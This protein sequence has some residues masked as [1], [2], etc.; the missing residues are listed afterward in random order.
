MGTPAAIEN[1][2]R[3]AA[4]LR[5]ENHPLAEWL[6]EA[7]ALARSGASLEAA[8]NLN[9]GYGAAARA[10]TQHAAL[11]VLADAAPAQSDNGRAA[12]IVEQVDRYRAGAWRRDEKTRKR[13][14]GVA[15]ACFDL[16]ATR[17]PTSLRSLRRR[18]PLL[19]KNDADLAKS[20]RA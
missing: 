3:I 1:L 4:F 5:N 6:L 13:P 7:M 20:S 9:H 19:A 11:R 15:G 8:L 16:L 17:A 2:G 10:E 12:W 14:P 18:L